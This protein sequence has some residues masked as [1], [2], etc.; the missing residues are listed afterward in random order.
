MAFCGGFCS[1][2]PDQAVILTQ[3]HRLRGYDAVQLATTLT[4]N[5]QYLAVGLP[6]L[7]FVTADNDLIIA[8]SDEGLAAENPNTYP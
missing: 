6:A 8:A 4:T 2:V 7:T 3:S 5:T 1:T